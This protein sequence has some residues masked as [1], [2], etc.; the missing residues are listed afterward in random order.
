ML[1]AVIGAVLS[2]AD[3]YGPFFL[4]SHVSNTNIA[5]VWAA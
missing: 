1:I 5:I 2:T 3:R 4:A